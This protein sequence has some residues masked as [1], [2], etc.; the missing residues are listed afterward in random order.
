M[1]SA[2]L[3]HLLVEA[4]ASAHELLDITRPVVLSPGHLHDIAQAM[5]NLTDACQHLHGW[6]MAWMGAAARQ[7]SGDVHE[8]AAQTRNRAHTRRVRARVGHTP[9]TVFS[10]L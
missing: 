7:R 6:G 9:R 1:D 4:R 2:H 8:C 3:H 10:L 5:L